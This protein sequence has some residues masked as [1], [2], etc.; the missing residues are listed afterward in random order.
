[1]IDGPAVVDANCPSVYIFDDEMAARCPPVAIAHL[2]FIYLPI[3][4]YLSIAALVAVCFKPWSIFY[5]PNKI[6]SYDDRPSHKC[7]IKY[8]PEEEFTTQRN[9]RA[10]R[11]S[12]QLWVTPWK[13][14]RCEATKKSTISW[15]RDEMSFRYQKRSFIN[16][17]MAN[18]VTPPMNNHDQL[19]IYISHSIIAS[20]NKNELKMP[21]D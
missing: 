10:P 17:C 21:K 6:H 15:E 3:S 11:L 14:M 12:R 16:S 8:P 9:D 13:G 7:P 2:H 1:M 18:R 5:Y 20:V 19:R 4:P